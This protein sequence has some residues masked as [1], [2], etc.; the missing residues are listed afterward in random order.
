MPLIPSSS[1]SSS[2]SIKMAAAEEEEEDKDARDDYAKRMDRLILALD[3]TSRERGDS[4]AVLVR[5]GRYLRAFEADGVGG[6]L[7]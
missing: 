5:E 6:G 4:V 7:G 2:S 3:T 1:S